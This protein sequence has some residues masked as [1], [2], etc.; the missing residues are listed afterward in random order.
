MYLNKEYICEGEIDID[1]LI[2]Q[3]DITEKVKLR[4]ETTKS[5]MIE[6]KKA[7]SFENEELLSCDC[8][9]KG[10]S[11]QCT[12]FKYSHNYISSYSVHDLARIGNSKEK[13]T[14]LINK[15][16]YEI[17]DI[18]EDFGLSD[19][20]KKQVLAHKLQQPLIEY[21]KIKN[22]LKQLVFP[23]YFLDYETLPYAIPLFNGFKPYQQI[24]FQFSL[25]VLNNPNSVPIHFE[26]LHEKK[27]DPSINIINKLLE[28]I[29][30]QGNIIVWH[31]SFEKKNK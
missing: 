15:R 22:E 19:I 13:L 17:D 23:L 4:T 28:F 20:Q 9:Y 1:K 6:V 12:T 18:P 7:L 21:E 25:H 5:K 31:A 2:K 3:D 10:R 8:I 27:S 24:P 26:Y 14:D 16:I 29:K 11:A 30:D